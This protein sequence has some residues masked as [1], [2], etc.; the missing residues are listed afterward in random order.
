MNTQFRKITNSLF[1][2][3]SFAI[4]SLSVNAQNSIGFNLGL[5]SYEGDL[6]CFEEDQQNFLNSAGVSFGLHLKKEL[7]K[8][9]AGRL[10]LQYARF[11][12]DDRD[13]AFSTGHPSRAYDF[14]NNLIELTV[15]LDLEPWKAK[16]FSPFL[17][18]GAGIASN[19]PST[20]FDFNN[21][22]KT[23]Q[24]LILT[25][26][27]ELK[28]FIFTVPVGVGFNVRVNELVTIGTEFGLRLGLSDYLDGVSLTAPTSNYND[29]FGTGAV[30]LNYRLG[31]ASTTTGMKK[32]P[33]ISTT[34]AVI[35]PAPSAPATSGETSAEMQAEK[36]AQEAKKAE[37]AAA[38]AA[39]EAELAAE[40]AAISAA[41]ATE[42]LA[43]LEAEMKDSDNDGIVDRLD[44]CPSIYA[45]TPSG[46]PA[47]E[48]NSDVNCTAVF[49]TRSVRFKTSFAELS[50][51]DK[52][53]LQAVIDILRNCPGK[54]LILEGH[55]DSAGSELVNQ[56]L[57]NSRANSVKAFLVR[58]GIDSGR[59]L[60]TGYGETRP[61]ADNSTKD[62]RTQ[63]RRVEILLSN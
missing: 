57:S 36:A 42:A 13:F 38:K 2:V 41:E 20:N 25:D 59:I 18:V 21:K 1:L 30:T 55:T 8:Y 28:N 37:M 27:A 51:P 39:R 35:V 19:N 26:Q 10:A 22:T 31:K 61:I 33:K 52:A 44:A 24:D 49:G 17:S 50:G 3:F 54:T 14:A 6:H 58:S 63:N 23:E 46:C 34:P 45:K 9:F 56:D 29:Y 4:L 43:K 12:G 53:T 47:T 40:K 60:A 5:S 16:R 48:V 15:R 32:T 62:G 11:Q 7:S